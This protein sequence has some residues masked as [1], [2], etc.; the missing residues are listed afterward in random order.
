MRTSI[1]KLICVLCAALMGILSLSGC[2]AAD[3]AKPS[4]S[5]EST[6]LSNTYAFVGKDIQNPY[7]QAVYE[8]FETACREIGVQALYKSP[9][10]TT[11]EK[12][13]EIIESLIERKVAGIAVAANDAD[14]LS[15]VLEEAMSEGI[16][17]ISL[18]SAVNKA[19]RQTHIQQAD[20]ETVGRELIRA[21]YDIVGGNGGMAILSA[22][23]QAT[24][25]NLW[26]EYMNKEIAE[27]PEKYANTP[28]VATV[29]GDDD[30]TKSMTE[31]EALLLND[32]VKVIISP[33]SVG[34]LAAAQVLE[35]EKSD[36]KL[37]G[38]GMPSQMSSYIENGISPMVFLWNPVDIGYLAGYT[39][40]AL[41]QGTITGA[42]GDSFAAG[43][44]GDRTVT[45]DNDGGSEV[46]LGE[47]LKFD[48]TNIARWKNVY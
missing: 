45:E 27:N 47:L 10:V 2:G 23:S 19:S 43:N 34:M 42:V 41:A 29:Y 36:V 31:T 17:I 7:M 44:L 39:M 33:T 37:T 46:I 38:L 35:E 40:D 18:D 11:P 15:S 16:K 5:A 13:I 22:T 9:E 25:Q 28:I 48:C 26:I 14:A 6:A 8:G 20:P 3:R 21:A 24:N 12:Q 32:D 1:R 4:P 30:L